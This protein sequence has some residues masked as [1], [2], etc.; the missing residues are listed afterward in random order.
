VNRGNWAERPEEVVIT[1]T[2]V[3]GTEFRADSGTRVP[4]QRLMAEAEAS[5]PVVVQGLYSGR[6]RLHGLTEDGDRRYFALSDDRGTALTV[7]LEAAALPGRTVARTF[8][9]TSSDNHVIQLSD[10]IAPEQIGRAL[11]HEVNE[12]LAVRERAARAE[13]PATRDLLVRGDALPENHRLSDEDLGRV[14]ELNF[15]AARM[16]DA[17]LPEERRTAARGELSQLIDHT[18]LRPVAPA[19]AA[20]ARAME[21]YAAAIRTDIVTPHLTSE[22]LRAVRELQSPVERLGHADAQAL[23]E[24]RARVAQ[25]GADARPTLGS[26]PAVQLPGLRS[27]GS[28]V[29]RE[30]LLA[31]RDEAARQR[32][33]VGGRTLDQLRAEA[34]ALP[35]GRYPRREIMIGGGAALAGRD[36]DVLLIDSRGRWHVDP[37][38]GIVQSADQVRHLREAGWD[39]Y[40]FA[41][42]KERVSLAAL[43]LWE[44]TA[45][46]KGPL[47]DGRASLDLADDGR[48]LARISPADG[49]PPVTVEVTGTPLVATGVPPEV[50]PGAD[51]QVPTMAE[52]TDVL[53]GHLTAVGTPEA[54]E[55]R[56]R[57]TA[58]PDGPGRA[59]ASLEVLADPR[60]AGALDPATA[61]Q[62]VA[63]RTTLEATAEWER[64]SAA[65]PGRV[66]LGDEVGDGHYDPTVADN[67]VIAG[68]G[69]G[70]IANT[71]II[72]EG[73]P[74]ARVTMVGTAAPWVL[75]NDAQYLDMRRRYDAELG[76]NGRLTTV[77]GRRLGAIETVNTPDGGVRFKAHDVE[78][79][80][81]VACLGRVAR[82]PGAADPLD[83]W[84]RQ[85]GGQVQGELLFDKHE[86][87]LGY[88]LRFE[89]G[90]RQHTVDVTG[91]ASRMLPRNI[92]SQEDMAR[93]AV[94]DRR[95]APAESG[96]VAAGFMATAL[97]GSHLAQHRAAQAGGTNPVVGSAGATSNTTADAAARTSGPAAGSGKPSA[98]TGNP[99]AGAAGLRSARKSSGPGSTPPG[100][101]PRIPRPPQPGGGAPGR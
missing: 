39:P 42:P 40:H 67:W 6:L 35:E 24:Y 4:E 30:E 64:A 37:I 14:G 59:A 86:Q 3:L 28:P 57:L 81:Y 71:E 97:Q 75:H 25:S 9:N 88:R 12:L 55:A 52:A 45:A 90:D 77:G 95:T 5:L 38:K 83:R 16:N 2:D 15:L 27:D 72:L 73:N 1:A 34:A 100:G 51:R 93:L 78:G 21:Q 43:Q 19:E 49:S 69:G 20:D 53:T 46:A 13:A 41:E 92:F 32:T 96:N 54:L 66:L 89:A 87:Y 47:V 62:T 65:A 60:L 58:L 82:L 22:A 8:V 68:I 44:D 91:A 10:R 17:T 76:G 61:P 85:Q 50:V 36:P 48:L 31:A 29:P 99:I 98:G 7:R 11:S 26:A 18:G 94:V 84:A 101:P 80:A 70:A 74:N 23:G 79:D 56:D 33:D 63:A